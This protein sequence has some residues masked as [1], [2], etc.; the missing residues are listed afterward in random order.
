MHLKELDANLIVVLDALLVDASVTKAASR[1][2]RSPSAVSHALA[3]LRE[4][5]DDPLFVRAGQRLVPTSKAEGLAPTIHVIVSGME[6]LLR[7][8]TPFDPTTQERTF[9]LA[10]RGAFELTLIHDLRYSIK[11]LAP[12]ISLNWQ[13]L[14]GPQSFEDMRLGKTH[15]LIK[16]GPSD[17]DAA[18]F[19]FKKLRSDV[20]ITIGKRNHPLT[21]Q[22]VS[23]QAFEQTEHILLSTG[24][25]QMHPFEKHLALHN[26]KLQDTIVASS[27]YVGI[28]IALETNALITLPATIV[29]RLKGYLA[30]TTIEQPFSKLSVPNYLIWHKSHDRDE[31][32]EWVRGKLIDLGSEDT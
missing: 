4:I 21:K 15:F 10:C 9:I 24:S 20:Y 32:H 30:F 19:Q 13:P 27:A 22:K 17:D 14:N 28:F 11:E 6:S 3:N 25:L 1:L 16:E 8:A 18:D 2:G 31:C 12:N 5:F 26:M 29:N 23:A 7:V